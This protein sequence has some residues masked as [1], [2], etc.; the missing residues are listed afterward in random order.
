MTFYVKHQVVTIRIV[1][2]ADFL[3]DCAKATT[4]IKPFL[5][6][7]VKKLANK[8]V[9]IPV[10]AVL[11]AGCIVRGCIRDG[12]LRPRMCVGSIPRQSLS[13]ISCAAPPPMVLSAA[14]YQIYSG[15]TGASSFTQTRGMRLRR[16]AIQP[17]RLTSMKPAI[18]APTPNT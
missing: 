13:L 6:Q 16:S 2:K 8:A 17:I 15:L 12:T 11:G 10:G 14:V 1:R 3:L 18:N 4:Q 7:G 5:Y 9:F